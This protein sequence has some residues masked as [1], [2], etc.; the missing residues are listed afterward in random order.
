[1][2]FTVLV[3]YNTKVRVKPFLDLFS[4]FKAPCFSPP[5]ITANVPVRIS[6]LSTVGCEPSV[7]PPT[8][9]GDTITCHSERSE[10]SAFLK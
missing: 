4:G 1:M 7:S 8:G 10:E 6:G 2:R 9:S 5:N 3:N